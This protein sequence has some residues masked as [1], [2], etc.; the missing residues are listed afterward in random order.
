MA[1]FSTG[2]HSP[3]WPCAFWSHQMGFR[4]LIQIT[5]TYNLSGP[6]Q[7]E[8]QHRFIKLLLK[9]IMLSSIDL[10]PKSGKPSFKTTSKRNTLS[11]SI[12]SETS[13]EASVVKTFAKQAWRPWIHVKVE[14]ESHPHKMSSDLHTGAMEVHILHAYHADRQTMIIRNK[15]KTITINSQ[16]H[17][18]LGRSPRWGKPLLLQNPSLGIENQSQG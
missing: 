4:N 5:H 10:T 16:K 1:S 9:F 13:W 12:S 3:P 7:S 14:G 8:L 6:A 11:G 18:E 15:I 17:K 2:A